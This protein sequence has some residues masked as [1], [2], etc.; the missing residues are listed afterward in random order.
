MK[1]AQKP[2][3]KKMVLK[4]RQKI[5][6]LRTLET[7]RED[8]QHVGITKK[9]ISLLRRRSRP[10]CTATEELI[11]ELQHIHARINDDIRRVNKGDFFAAT[12]HVSIA[13]G[14]NMGTRFRLRLPP[15]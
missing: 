3:V 5:V 7:M 15:K 10:K 2:V 13:E 1:K 9:Q 8:L 4:N 11:E 6:L 12:V 14:I